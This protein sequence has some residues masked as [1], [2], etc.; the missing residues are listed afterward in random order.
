MSK[1]FRVPLISQA[2]RP[3]TDLAAY[4][5]LTEEVGYPPS[6][7]ASQPTTAPGGAPGGGSLSQMSAK[8]ISDV[9]GWKGK[10]GD[11]KGFVGALT[12]SF[13]L[14]EVE[15]HVVSTWMP[16][17]YAVQ[18]D[19]S[20]GITG[21]QASIYTRAKE[22]LDQSLPLLDGLYA[23]DPEADADDVGALKAVA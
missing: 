8:A 2:K 11:V 12:Q 13:T 18:T 10:S 21:A 5:I 15:G 1:I 9:L 7:I 19:L 6:P 23:L 22:A 20:G 3:L 14:T 17:S 16:R 4:P